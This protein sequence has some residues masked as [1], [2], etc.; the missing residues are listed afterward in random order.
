[1]VRACSVGGGVCVVQC[2]R[3]VRS[4]R[5]AVRVCVVQRGVWCVVRPTYAATRFAQRSRL[6]R[7]AMPAVCK[8][9]V[10]YT[11]EM[12]LRMEVC[13]CPGNIQYGTHSYEVARRTEC[14]EGR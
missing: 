5:Q 8:R 3:G 10:E 14:H 1:V 4:V 9:R 13:V 2:G 12:A 6:L 11:A 7:N